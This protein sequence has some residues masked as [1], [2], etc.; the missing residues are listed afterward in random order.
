MKIQTTSEWESSQGN[1]FVPQEMC[2]QQVFF[3]KMPSICKQYTEK[4]EEIDLG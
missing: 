2:G 1:Y 3:T 4:Q